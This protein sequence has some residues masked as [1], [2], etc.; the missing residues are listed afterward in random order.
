MKIDVELIYAVA[1]SARRDIAEATA[2]N[3][4]IIEQYGIT[5]PAD[6]A[7]FL[8]QT[9]TETGGFNR[10]EENLFYTSTD[11]LRQVWPSRFPS[12]A[13]AAPYVRN[14]QK[15]ANLVYGNRG[16]NRPGT[17]DGWNFRGSGEIQTTFHDGF[18][19]VDQEAGLSSV[20]SPDILR[21]MPGALQAACVFW[22]HNRLS[23]FATSGDIVGLTKAVN[24]GLTGL[25]DR[26]VFTDR[27]MKAIIALPASQ[28]R[29]RDADDT[30]IRR[31]MTGDA[32]SAIQTNLQAHGYYVGGVIDGKY[33]DG[34]E[35]AVRHFQ[36]EHGLN[37]DG[38]VGPATMKALTA[39]AAPT[40]IDPVMTDATAGEN[41]AAPMNLGG[42]IANVFRAILTAIS[43]SRGQH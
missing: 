21:A 42:L 30:M 20:A 43:S 19:L 23:R 29:Q 2:A 1:P 31:G 6:L 24:G 34:T 16:G 5:E 13:A 25:A 37:V 35:D 7:N 4:A 15:L 40:P 33:G 12:D 41:I 22:R 32:V 26:R 11:R 38:V 8:G 27:A 39:S 9:A 36:G 14:P 17:N 10:L 28:A 3:S 18:A